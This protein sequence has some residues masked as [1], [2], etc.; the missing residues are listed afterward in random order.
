MSDEQLIAEHDR[1]VDSCGTT[2]IKYYLEELKRRE[3]DRQ[4]RTIIKYTRL[5]LW[6]TVLVALLTITNVIAVVLPLFCG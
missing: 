1:A 2:G 6:L 5:M 4:T 3:Q